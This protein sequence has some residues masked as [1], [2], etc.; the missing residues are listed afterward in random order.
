MAALKI[1]ISHAHDEKSL[2]D[3]WKS[4][5]DTISLG[6]VKTWFSSDSTSGGGIG[7]GEEWRNSLYQQLGESDF[8]IT[9]QTPASAGR[10]W[11]MWEC[12]AASG[13]NKERGIIPIVF[14]MGRGDLA[15]PLT[16]Y[17]VYS[18]ENKRQVYEVCDRLLKHGGLRLNEQFFDIAFE[19]Y[20]AAIELHRPRRLIGTEQMTLW[21]TRF[22]ELIRAGRVN[23]VVP[24]R[25]SMYLSLGSPFKPVEPTLHELLSKILLDHRN[26]QEAVEEADYALSLVSED[27]DLL[28]RKA[29]ALVEMQ[30]LPAAEEI[31]RRILASHQDLKNNPELASLEGRIH[32]ER[33]RATNDRA[34]LESAFASYL[35]AYRSDP[36]QYYPGVNAA[37][38]ALAKGDEQTAREIYAEVA[39]TCRLL[40][41]RRD[42]SF[43]VDFTAGEARLGSGDIPAALANYRQAL[44]RTPP[45]APRDSSSALGGARRIVEAMKLG[46]DV[47]GQI[48]Q[49]LGE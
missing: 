22:E 36:A 34:H 7:V 11:I 27:V 38:L 18:G 41:Q 28:H 9:I 15:N 14:S 26:Y 29:L 31:V 25:Q 46:D 2:A 13:I 19:T 17:Q 6:A 45:P 16:S 8:I 40:Q 47:L 4:L 32:R 23:E 3:A 42:V 35:R 21:R 49:I 33:W 48:E 20:Q 24:K 37:S 30:N 44:T 12:G 1:L 10:P 5:L 39:E 43:W